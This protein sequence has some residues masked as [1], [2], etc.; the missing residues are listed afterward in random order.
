VVVR[1]VVVRLVAVRLV[2]EL[3]VVVV[4]VRGSGAPRIWRAKQKGG[5][6]RCVWIR[7]MIV[8]L[9]EVGVG[10]VGGVVVVGVVVV[11]VVV[12]RPPA[13]LVLVVRP[14]DRLLVVR[15]PARL[16]VNVSVRVVVKKAVVGIRQG[17]EVLY[18]YPAIL[19]GVIIHAAQD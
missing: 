5:R 3:V 18:M 11:V 16:R 10:E 9:G 15:P 12:V 14:L 19:Y 2:V 6:R 7:R 17:V 4:V 8:I 13:R 1:L